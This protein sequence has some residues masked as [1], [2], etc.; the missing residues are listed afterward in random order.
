M[1]FVFQKMKTGTSNQDLEVATRCP[2]TGAGTGNPSRSKFRCW[3]L[4]ILVAVLLAVGSVLAVT[5]TVLILRDGDSCYALVG[6]CFFI[7]D[8][9]ILICSALY[10]LTSQHQIIG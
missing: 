9:F 1:L 8:I 10:Y 3:K 4:I 6:V 2:G 7:V 5:L